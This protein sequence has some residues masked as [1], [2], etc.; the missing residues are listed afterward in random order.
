MIISPV[1][2][3]KS[4]E[5][6]RGSG[7]LTGSQQ[8]FWLP[9]GINVR[10][11]G[12]HGGLQGVKSVMVVP[13]EG[14]FTVSKKIGVAGGRGS[15]TGSTITMLTGFAEVSR[16]EPL[17]PAH[18]LDYH[19]FESLRKNHQQD[20]PKHFGLLKASML[21]PFPNMPREESTLAWS[22]Y[23][24]RILHVTGAEG[25]FIHFFSLSSFIYHF[26]VTQKKSS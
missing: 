1:F 18:P 14:P 20:P 16:D 24:S 13:V 26:H 6:C 25:G 21:A 2:E 17:P 8:H 19:F 23:R 10:E 11:P 3:K 4:P 22:H 15:S 9:E 7:S 5:G 12:H